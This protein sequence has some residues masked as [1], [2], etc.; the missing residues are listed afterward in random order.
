[1]N[2]LE[3]TVQREM[4]NRHL[5]GY[6]PKG[7]QPSQVGEL[8]EIL[9]GDATLRYEQNRS[10]TL[11]DILSGIEGYQFGSLQASD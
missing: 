11:N 5:C 4:R 6:V 10:D 2:E 8:T 7:G 1:M 9:I 3:R